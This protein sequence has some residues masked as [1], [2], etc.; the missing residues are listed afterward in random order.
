MQRNLAAAVT[1]LEIHVIAWP[2][3]EDSATLITQE[4]RD[5]GYEATVLFALSGAGHPEVPKDWVVVNGFGYGKIFER[6]LEISESDVLLH[7]HA[8]CSAPSWIEVAKRCQGLFSSN[9]NLG[10]WSPI[11]DWSS[12]NL[13][14]TKVGEGPVPETHSVTTVDGIVWAMSSPVMDKLRTL[15]YSANPRGWGIDLA[16]SAIAHNL[17]LAVVMD[18]AILVNHPRG[19][20]YDHGEAGRESEDFVQQ[21]QS[22]ELVLYRHSLD[23]A[24]MRIKKEKS[25]VKYRVTRA[26]KRLRKFLFDPI[27]RLV[28]MR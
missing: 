4:L 18:E 8:D 21:L 14:R 24:R 17:G 7:V 9:A 28:L 3:Q 2:G 13:S 15:T 5:S 25:A 19:S 10:V 16:A 6:S 1:T 11:V 26:F 20:G 27:Y 12:W 22:D 23:V